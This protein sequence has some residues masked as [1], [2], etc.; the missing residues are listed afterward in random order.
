M[1]QFDERTTGA[2]EGDKLAAIA[3]LRDEAAGFTD[4]E[5]ERALDSLLPAFPPKI[6]LQT[7]TRC[8]A[9]CEMCPY[10]EV[11]GPDYPH[12]LMPEALYREILVQLTGRPVERLSLFLMNEPLLDRRLPDWIA[13]ARGAL[14]GV[15]LG[16]FTNG[17]PLGAS[18]ARRLAE[19]GLDELCISV[20]G[21]DPRAYQA[22]M[23]GLSFARV[24]A[25]VRAIL[26]LYE[27]GALGRMRVQLVTGDV[28]ELRASVERAEPLL[29]RHTLLKAFSNEREVA[30]VRPGLPS[31]PVTDPGAR[32]PLCQRPFVKLYVLADGECILCNVDWRKSMTLGRIGTGAEGQIAT[33]WR[34]A[35][36]RA[37]RLLHLRD[38]FPCGQL[39]ERCDYPA[40]ADV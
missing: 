19:A 31:S 8:N 24:T 6:Q 28:P 10:P 3:Q 29:R 13:L 27:A 1:R 21:F 25:N 7:A 34:G 40:V 30:T 33:L 39:C 11:I 2:N 14:P 18:L 22:A 20:H 17:S 26:G 15:T 5:L 23:R 36:Y 38:S 37:A 9:A 4:E 35:R 12:R 32:R 16:L